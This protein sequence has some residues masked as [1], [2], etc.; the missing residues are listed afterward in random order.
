MNR[1]YN[2]FLDLVALLGFILLAAYE[3]LFHGKS[4]N[5]QEGDL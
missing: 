3:T 1:L 5:E 4:I 2:K